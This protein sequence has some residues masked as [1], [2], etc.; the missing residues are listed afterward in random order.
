MLAVIGSSAHFGQFVQIL[1]E[2]REM[3]AANPGFDPVRPVMFATVRRCEHDDTVPQIGERVTSR[4]GDLF[5][6]RYEIL[7]QIFER[8]FAH[9]EETDAQL[10][11]LADAT[12]GTMLAAC[13]GRSGPDHDAAGRTGS[14]GAHRG[15]ELRALLRGRRPPPAS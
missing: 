5:N 11:T 3:V 9:T 1:D 14:S 12:V 13:S 15:A 10:A 7:L 4:C 8:Y 6:V 2:Y